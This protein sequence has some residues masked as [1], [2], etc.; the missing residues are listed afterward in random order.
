[1]RILTVNILAA[2]AA[3]A[4][5][6]ACADFYW[7]AVGIPAAANTAVDSGLGNYLVLR[8][9]DPS[10]EFDEITLWDIRRETTGLNRLCRHDLKRSK[11]FYDGCPAGSVDV[12]LTLPIKDAEENDY[13]FVMISSDG[14]RDNPYLRSI[15]LPDSLEAIGTGAFINAKNL[16]AFLF[17]INS[18]NLQSIGDSVFRD[19]K[20]L[21]C[22]E[23]PVTSTTMK[24]YMCNNAGIVGVS[25]P[26]VTNIGANAFMTTPNLRCVEFGGAAGQTIVFKAQAFQG[27]GT[28]I[29]TLLFH[30]ATP[31]LADGFVNGNNNFLDHVG[32]NGLLIFLPMNAD[33]NGPTSA[34][35]TWVENYLAVFP[36]SSFTFP[37]KD[38]DGT[39]TDGSWYHNANY[40]PARKTYVVRFWD[41]DS[42]ATSALLSY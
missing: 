21:E 5:L 22:L 1:M 2:F 39:W 33:K 15:K 20:S 4:V 9:T 8:N 14:F 6:P 25:L 29:K 18:A 30:E 32:F 12:D 38:A 35:S 24:G 3:L 10:V 17:P 7:L 28:T 23:W 26:A 13:T 41:P 11:E 36:G 37:V 31:D 34:W 40:A 16:Q 42:T 27:Q 19:C